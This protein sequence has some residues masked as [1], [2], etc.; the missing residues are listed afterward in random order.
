MQGASSLD[1]AMQ[2]AEWYDAMFSKQQCNPDPQNAGQV[3]GRNPGPNGQTKSDK[4]GKPRKSNS[5]GAFTS[6]N[7]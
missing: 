4:N 6:A 5:S 3:K 1:T 7:N 2:L